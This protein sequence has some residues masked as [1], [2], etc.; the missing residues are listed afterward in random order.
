MPDTP[1]ERPRCIIR[2]RNKTGITSRDM[3]CHRAIRE[4]EAGLWGDECLIDESYLLSFEIP[5]VLRRVATYS[6][7][8]GFQIIE[9]D[10]DFQNFLRLNDIAQPKSLAISILKDYLSSQNKN[11]YAIDELLDGK[12]NSTLSINKKDQE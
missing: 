1:F 9:I 5:H 4:A 11:E 3:T 8:R 10:N 2:D 7:I 6:K 12:P